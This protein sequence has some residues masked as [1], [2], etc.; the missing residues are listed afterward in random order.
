MNLPFI[1]RELLFKASVTVLSFHATNAY[2]E[3]ENNTNGIKSPK[4]NYGSHNESSKII[5]VP[6]LGLIQPDVCD[7]PNPEPRIKFLSFSLKY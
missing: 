2:N 5:V 3:N 1:Y 6:F 7:C 4:S